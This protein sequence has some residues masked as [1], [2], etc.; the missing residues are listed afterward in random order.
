MNEPETK[1]YQPVTLEH[2][3]GLLV[4]DDEPEVCNTIYHLLRRRF[5]VLRAHSALEGMYLMEHHEFE[6][7]LTDQRMPGVTGVELLKKVKTKYPEAIRMLYTGYMDM[8]SLVKA[9]ND[10]HIYRF[11]SK[12]WQPEELISAVDDAAR[13]FHRISQTYEELERTRETLQVLQQENQALSAR[14]GTLKARLHSPETG[15]H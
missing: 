5:N 12:P 3:H 1:V 7:V 9:V 2:K 13:E 11:I 4:V 10:G 8:E 15:W 6:I 14:L